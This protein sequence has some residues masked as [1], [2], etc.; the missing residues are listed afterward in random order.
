MSDTAHGKRMRPSLIPALL[1]FTLLLQPAAAQAGWVLTRG[2]LSRQP[3]ELQSI[4]EEG[5]RCLVAGSAQII[6]LAQFVQIERQT[7]PATA[8]QSFILVLLAGDRIAGEPAGYENERLTWRNSLLGELSI[9]LTAVRAILRRELTDKSLDEPPLDDMVHLANGDRVAGILTS[10]DA[11][12][13]TVSADGVDIQLP[14]A[15]VAWIDLAAAV[16]PGGEGQAQIFR[17]RFSDGSAATVRSVRSEGQRLVMELAGGQRPVEQSAVMA[18]EHLRGPVSWLSSRKPLAVVQVPYLSAIPWPTRMDASVSGR[19]IQ[20][21][22]R[23]YSRG[24]GVRAYSRI[25]FALAGD[26]RAFQTRYAIASDARYPYADVTVRILVDDQAVHERKNVR[27]GQPAQQVVVELPAG[28]SKLSLAVDYGE[29]NDTHDHL[30]WI[31]PALLR[32]KPGS[33]SSDVRGS[34]Q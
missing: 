16:Q 25:D 34:G 19:P 23:T 27:A 31:E 17:V 21:G 5:V 6:P 29:G 12:G 11:E 4:G 1:T 30:D 15:A 26:Y 33:G 18:I 14:L 13:A 22:G 32:E 24:I 7:P 20:H 8:Q 2:D 28:A 3:A 10:L 9:P